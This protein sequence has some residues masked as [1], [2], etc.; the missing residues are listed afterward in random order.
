[1]YGGGSLGQLLDARLEFVLDRAV[2]DGYLAG[3]REAGADVPA[4]TVRLGYV[5]HAALWCGLVD[6]A[7]IAGQAF[8]NL[9]V[10]TPSSTQTITVANTSPSSVTISSVAITGPARLDHDCIS[11]NLVAGVAGC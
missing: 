7:I 4:E 5:L 8:G 1:M 10:G 6:A 11:G 2:F 3:L 9:P